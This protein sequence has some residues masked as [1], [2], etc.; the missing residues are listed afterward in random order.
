MQSCRSMSC[1]RGLWKK[2]KL[3]EN[4]KLMCVYTSL[5]PPKQ[6]PPKKRSIKIFISQNRLVEYFDIYSHTL[7]MLNSTIRSSLFPRNYGV[8]NS[9]RNYRPGRPKKTV[10]KYVEVQLLQD[11]PHVGVKGEIKLVKPGFMKNYLYVANKACY[12]NADCPPKIPVVEPEMEIKKEKVKKTKPEEETVEEI[13]DI[14]EET[15]PTA[16]SLEELSTLFSSMKKTSTKNL[17]TK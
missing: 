16:M 8:L 15:E 5:P 10:S 7:A 1:I 17:Q 3:R 6:K 14:V 12:V 13:V 2:K 4:P 11:I 9:I